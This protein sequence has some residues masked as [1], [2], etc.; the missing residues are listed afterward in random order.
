MKTR[1]SV[2]V[3]VGLVLVVAAG[4][5]E[6]G[7]K[8]PEGKS[9]TLTVPMAVTLH[10][11][12]T[13]VVQIGLKRQ[14]MNEGV[15]VSIADLPRGVKAKESSMNVETDS[16]TFILQ[17]DKDADLVANQTVAVMMEGPD[18]MRATEH[19]RLTVKE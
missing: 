13:S 11:G 17:A 5:Q 19:F 15:Q 3:L 18:G 6:T 7:V 1:I 16:A 2:A 12:T 9:M 4:C 8:G 10:R 14:N